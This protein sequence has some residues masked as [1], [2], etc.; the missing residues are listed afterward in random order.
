MEQPPPEL[1][2]LFLAFWFCEGPQ[3]PGEPYKNLA[4]PVFEGQVRG[5]SFVV[6]LFFYFSQNVAMP[7]QV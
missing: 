7:L 1:R 2:D 5:F 4:R 3:T 6:A